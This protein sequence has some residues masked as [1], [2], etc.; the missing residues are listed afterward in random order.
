VEII[1]P[2]DPTADEPQAYFGQ[3]AQCA[4]RIDPTVVGFFS[5]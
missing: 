4:F 3:F 2:F 5:Q 1:P